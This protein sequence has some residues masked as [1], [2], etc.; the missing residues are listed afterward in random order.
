[1][2]HSILLNEAVNDVIAEKSHAGNLLVRMYEKPGCTFHS[3]GMW[4]HGKEG[5]SGGDNMSVTYIGSSNFGMRS[6]TRDF[7]LGFLL[8]SCDSS[9]EKTISREWNYL[10]GHAKKRETPARKTVVVKN[11]IWSR[12]FAKIMSVAFKSFL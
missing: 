11:D 5:V 7:E 2:M 12:R 9:D 8:V 3:K 4:L 1:M 10:V 6:W